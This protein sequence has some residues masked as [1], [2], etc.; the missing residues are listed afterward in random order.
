MDKRE[1]VLKQLLMYVDMIGH[2]TEILCSIAFLAIALN[3]L[4]ASISKTA[5]VV[6]SLNMSWTACIAASAPASCPTQTCNEPAAFIKSCLLIIITTF[7]DIFPKISPT[8]IGLN[9][10]LLLRG[11]SLH[12]TKLSK[13]A[14]LMVFDIFVIH[15]FLTSSGIALRRSDV[16][17]PKHDETII[18]LNP[19]A[20]NPDGSEPPYVLIA[21]FR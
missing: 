16:T 18:L 7:P 5:S 8:P 21:A 1:G 6:W 19:S 20:S 15:N 11:I 9:P 12:A 3:V 17:V 2:M 14:Q 10:G 4:L 13:D